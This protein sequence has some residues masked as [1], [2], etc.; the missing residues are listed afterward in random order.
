MAT[1]ANKIG[2]IFAD[3]Q[4]IKT[5]GPALLTAWRES[6]PNLTG[7]VVDDGFVLVGDAVSFAVDAAAAAVKY[8]EDSPLARYIPIAG[9]ILSL[10][11]ATKDLIEWQKSEQENANGPTQFGHYLEVVGDLLQGV[12]S[13]INLSGQ[14]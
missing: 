13:A 2:G 8:I 12:G 6:G 7:E 1:T 10:N 11:A 4:A 5:D 3:I 9:I 14:V